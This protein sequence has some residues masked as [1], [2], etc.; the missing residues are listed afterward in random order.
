[1]P[2][3]KVNNINIGEHIFG[4]GMSFLTLKETYTPAWKI[5]NREMLANL[6]GT[7]DVTANN[8]FQ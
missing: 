7:H 6:F 3:K 5:D 8:I 1:M 2:G 4:K